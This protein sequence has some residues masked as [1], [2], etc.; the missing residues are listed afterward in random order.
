[1]VTRALY[2]LLTPHWWVGGMTKSPVLGK[3]GHGWS[4]LAWHGSRAR[5]L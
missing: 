5:V 3:K 2:Q 1:M 4:Y